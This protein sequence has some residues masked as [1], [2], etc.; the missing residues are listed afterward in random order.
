MVPGN[1][2]ICGG[3]ELLSGGNELLS[4]GNDLITGG[5]ELVSGGN[6][7][8]SVIILIGP[9]WL[10]CIWPSLDYSP[11]DLEP[12]RGC[13]INFALHK[14]FYYILLGIIQSFWGLSV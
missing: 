9:Q 7:L 5:N 14:C 2:L 10:P 1:E 3:N 8:D 6:D 4:G 11:F 13:Y 12:I